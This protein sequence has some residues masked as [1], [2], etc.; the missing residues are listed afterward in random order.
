MSVPSFAVWRRLVKY[1]LNTKKCLLHYARVLCG[2]LAADET[3]KD[4][5]RT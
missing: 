3:E 5:E 4:E 2:F 1:R